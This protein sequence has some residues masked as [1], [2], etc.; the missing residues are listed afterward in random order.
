MRKHFLTVLFSVIILT[1]CSVKNDT[2]LPDPQIII[3]HWNLVEVTGG[4]VGADHTFPLETIVWDFNEI[5]LKLTVTNNNADD[6]KEDALTSG[7]YPYSVT[8]ANGKTYLSITGNEF[9]RFVV[10]ANKLV[11]DQNDLSQG[12]GADGYIYTF[13]KTEEI[14]N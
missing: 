5:D 14:V 7:T 11:I 8:N 10:T 12:S 3:V 6:T 13:E 4:V 2:Q 1:S 9:G